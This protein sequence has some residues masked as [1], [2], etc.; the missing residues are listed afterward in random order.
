[1]VLKMNRTSTIVEKRA[2]SMKVESRYYGNYGRTIRRRCA[3]CVLNDNKTRCVTCLSIS[4][5]SDLQKLFAETLVRRYISVERQ[6]K[7]DQLVSYA[8]WAC[9]MLQVR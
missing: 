2:K 3:N 7:P 1:M 5:Q 9:L 6:Q 8:S 4:Y